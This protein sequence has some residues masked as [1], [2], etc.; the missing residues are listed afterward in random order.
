MPILL[1]IYLLYYK[2]RKQLKTFLTRNG[3]TVPLTLDSP[4][5]A[6][7]GPIEIASWRVFLPETFFFSPYA[8]V[9]ISRTL[10]TP[11]VIFLK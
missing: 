5:R 1:S 6:E 11:H 4:V 9:H 2:H 8:V 3:S 10:S 7:E